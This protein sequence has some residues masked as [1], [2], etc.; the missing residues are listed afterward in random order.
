MKR[1]LLDTMC[2][3]WFL[4]QVVDF[5]ATAAVDLSE[6]NPLFLLVTKRFSKCQFLAALFSG[7]HYFVNAMSVFIN[8]FKFIIVND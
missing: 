7:N 2:V 3:V 5:G 8:D 4:A 6:L 1:I